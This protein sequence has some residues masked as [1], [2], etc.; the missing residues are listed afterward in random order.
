[1]SARL[2]PSAH[3]HFHP[4]FAFLKHFFAV[5]VRLSNFLQSPAARDPLIQSARVSAP[6]HR[7]WGRGGGGTAMG[8]E[9]GSSHVS[10]EDASQLWN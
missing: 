3:F 10:I 7:F 4:D 2:Q 6:I 5:P 9:E 1:M 8:G